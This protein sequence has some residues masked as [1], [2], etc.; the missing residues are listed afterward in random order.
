M[1]CPPDMVT[2]PASS[3]TSGF[4]SSAIAAPT[5]TAFCSTRNTLTRTRRITR[6]MPPLASM[7]TSALRPMVEKKASSR[8]LCSDMS[9]EI[10]MPAP[11]RSAVIT[12]A[13]IRPP[14]TGSG[15]L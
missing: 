2:E 3:P 14:T 10:R 6:R 11:K 4:M 12:N 7:R 1:P 5:P 8:V 15:M 9:N 13:A